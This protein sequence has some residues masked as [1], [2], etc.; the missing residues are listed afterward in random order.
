MRETNRE[1][2]TVPGTGGTGET[3]PRALTPEEVR[4]ATLRQDAGRPK[5]E[6]LEEAIRLSR[7]TVGLAAAGRRAKS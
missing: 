7:F 1:K 2:L 3:G 5:G 4:R 6:L